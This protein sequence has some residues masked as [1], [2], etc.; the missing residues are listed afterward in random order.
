MPQ[1]PSVSRPTREGCAGLRLRTGAA[2]EP[3]MRTV[4]RVVSWASILVC[5]LWYLFKLECLFGV[6]LVLSVLTCKS[7]CLKWL[8]SYLEMKIEGV[9]IDFSFP[10]I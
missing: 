9:Y 6:E 3:A 8:R 7:R 5:V 2:D 4:R 1:T 10:T